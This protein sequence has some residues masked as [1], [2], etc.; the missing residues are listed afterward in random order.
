MNIREKQFIS[1]THTQR[2]DTFANTYKGE[3]QQAKNGAMDDR[4]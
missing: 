3:T 4:K 2:N 1:T